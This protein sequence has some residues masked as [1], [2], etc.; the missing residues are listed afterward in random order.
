MTSEPCYAL[1]GPPAK[2]IISTRPSLLRYCMGSHGLLVG[3]G[4]QELIRYVKKRL[5][6]DWFRLMQFS[7]NSMQ[8]RFNSVQ[9]SN[10]PD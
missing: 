8:K 4:Y 5:S 10:K 3:P 7:G 1:S 6:S 9:R 2:Q